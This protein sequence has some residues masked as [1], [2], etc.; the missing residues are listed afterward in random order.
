MLVRVADA[1][2]V[3]SASERLRLAVAGLGT[4]HPANVPHGNRHDQPR[5]RVRVTADLPE[6]DDQWF[7]RADAALYRAKEAGRESIRGGLRARRRAGPRLAAAPMQ[8]AAAAP[9]SPGR[10]R[11]RRSAASAGS[12]AAR[13][14]STTRPAAQDDPR[15]VHHR[16]VDPERQLRRQAERGDARRSPCR[17]GRGL[18]GR[19]ERRLAC[20]EPVPDDAVD[21]EPMG[22][23]HDARGIDRRRALADDDDRVGRI[24][25]ARSRRPRRTRPCRRG[26]D[27]TRTARGRRAPRGP[28]PASPGRG[29]AGRRRRSRGRVRSWPKRYR[30][31]PSRRRD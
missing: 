31:P 27:R 16:G 9:G 20:P 11:P 19:G 15:P 25:Q 2:G 28:P 7:A 30:T 12:T 29:R 24:L 21:V 5:R 13:A 22:G 1:D 18:V 26:P 14:P 8:R 10:R 3:R 4:G 6:T 23:E 17:S